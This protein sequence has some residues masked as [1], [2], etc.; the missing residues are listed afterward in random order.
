[1]TG[2]RRRLLVCCAVVSAAAAMAAAALTLPDWVRHRRL[3]RALVAASHEFEWHWRE[4]LQKLRDQYGDEEVAKAIVDLMDARD[5]TARVFAVSVPLAPCDPGLEW[6]WPS[7]RRGILRALEDEDRRVR[8]EA[9]VV[10]LRSRNPRGKEW[11][12]IRTALP[13]MMRNDPVSGCR[14]TA[15]FALAKLGS[16]EGLRT[17]IEEIAHAESASDVTN[18]LAWLELLIEPEARAVVDYGRLNELVQSRVESQQLLIH[19]AD[20]AR[21][22]REW[23]KSNAQS[24][25]YDPAQWKFVLRDRGATPRGGPEQDH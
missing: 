12:A 15:G 24:V 2:R 9:A 5:P 7:L 20:L 21:A 10:A 3:R 8:R 6:N 19:A 16:R 22:W 11:Q 17:V 4:T 23:Y 13:D 1:M 14:A 18:C 25:R